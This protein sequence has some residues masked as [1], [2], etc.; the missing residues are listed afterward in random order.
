MPNG[1][2]V[3][4]RP[5]LRGVQPDPHDRS[6]QAG[7][8]QHQRTPKPELGQLSAHWRGILGGKLCGGECP[9]PRRRCQAAVVTWRSS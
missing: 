1:H 9:P 7:E 3:H 5:P 6:Q 2:R 8:E 4:P